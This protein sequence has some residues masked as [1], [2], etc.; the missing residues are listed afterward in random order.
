MVGA[1]VGFTELPP[2]SA[3]ITTATLEAGTVVITYSSVC[4]DELTFIWI[5][6]IGDSHSEA[7]SSSCPV[8]ALISRL[9]S[10]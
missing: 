3:S 7:I 6:I 10:S 1:T 4:V 5:L 9:L 8:A 2:L